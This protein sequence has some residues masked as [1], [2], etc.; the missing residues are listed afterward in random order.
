MTVS[1]RLEKDLEGLAALG[2]P[3]EAAQMILRTAKQHKTDVRPIAVHCLG[4]DRVVCV[5]VGG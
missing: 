1:V 5:S 3:H 4:Y 2:G